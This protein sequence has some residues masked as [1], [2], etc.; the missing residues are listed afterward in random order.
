M[1]ASGPHNSTL[2]VTLET[3]GRNQNRLHLAEGERASAHTS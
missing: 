1:T 2:E 3:G